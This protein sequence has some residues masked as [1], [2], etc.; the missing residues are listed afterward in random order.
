LCITGWCLVCTDL[1]GQERQYPPARLETTEEPAALSEQRGQEL[2][3]KLEDARRAVHSHPGSAA[4][5]FS[6]GLVQKQLGEIENATES[7]DRALQINSQLADVS[8]ERGLIA[9]DQQKWMQASEYFRQALAAAPN[10]IRARLAHGEMNLRMGDFDAAV[11]EFSTVLRLD[12]FNSSAHYG[13]GLVRLQ[14]GELADAE[15]EFLH[16]LSQQPKTVAVQE[17]LG[18]TLV[19]EH[20]WNDALPVLRAVLSQNQKSIEALNALATTLEGQGDKA[21]AAEQFKRARELSRQELLLHRTQGENNQGLVYWHAGQLEDAAAAFRRAIQM[22]PDYAESHNNLGGVLW[23]LNESAPALAE[24]QA[25]VRYSPRFAEAHNNWG[26]VLLRA[27]EY[28]Y[29]IEQFRAALAIR[30]GFALAHLNLG[31]AMVGNHHLDWAEIEFRNAA[32]LA[33]K[34]A[35]AHVELGLLVAARHGS[36]SPDARAELEEALRL[37]SGLRSSIPAEYL[38][39]LK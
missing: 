25:A 23:Q 18:Q 3:F 9:A 15:S 34:M 21:G 38:Q 29:A 11:G 19:R 7:F 16:A 14:Q 39:K 5:Y 26:T 2:L 33:P 35:A 31:Y 17:S 22:K 4:G 8:Y 6:L 36:L 13:I 28:E 20:K 32:T 1:Q 24:F 10:H 12:H 37:D 30:P 27:G